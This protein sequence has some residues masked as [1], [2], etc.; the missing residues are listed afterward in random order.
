MTPPKF[1]ELWIMWMDL[2]WLV[3][4]SFY[5]LFAKITFKLDNV[6]LYFLLS[7]DVKLFSNV[8]FTIA[9]GIVFQHY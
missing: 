6:Q 7:Y 8:E 5:I 1:E 9:M 4:A 3:V 2:L